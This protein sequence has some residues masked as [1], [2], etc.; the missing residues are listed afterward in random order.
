MQPVDQSINTICTR[1][2][3]GE[4]NQ[5]GVPGLDDMDTLPMEVEGRTL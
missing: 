2:I 5:S 3:S 1:S 4:V